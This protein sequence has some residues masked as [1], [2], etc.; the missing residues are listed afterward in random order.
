MPSLPPIL[1]ENKESRFGWDSEK[2]L[3][4][5]KILFICKLSAVIIK[6]V[7]AKSIGKVRGHDI[8]YDIRDRTIL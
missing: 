7:S 4:M 3:S 8:L 1:V 5:E 6:V 2:S